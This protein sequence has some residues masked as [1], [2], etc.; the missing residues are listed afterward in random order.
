MSQPK[1]VPFPRSSETVYQKSHHK[2]P[3]Q[4]R[5]SA[6]SESQWYK[7]ILRLNEWMGSFSSIQHS[8]K[9]TGCEGILNS[10]FYFYFLRTIYVTDF[11][12]QASCCWLPASSLI[13]L[14]FPS[15][16]DWHCI[17]TWESCCPLSCGAEL[18][19]STVLNPRLLA[20]LFT[21]V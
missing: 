7:N 1:P 16:Q 17:F 11:V 9:T 18:P 8:V 2:Y 3:P 15:G 6:E 4:L 21:F 13:K 19:L 14:S 12:I 5:L 20:C 10:I